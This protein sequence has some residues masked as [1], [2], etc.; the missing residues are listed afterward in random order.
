MAFGIS[1]LS[2]RWYRTSPG[3]G[4]ILVFGNPEVGNLDFHLPP[5]LL[6]EGVQEGK[7]VTEVVRIM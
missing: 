6:T 4:S 2:L 1:P 5:T 3:F 7:K